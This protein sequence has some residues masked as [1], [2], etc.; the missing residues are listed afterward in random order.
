[1]KSK[2]ILIVVILV[3]ASINLAP[4]YAKDS[5]SNLDIVIQRTATAGQYGVVHL[6]DQF[7]LTNIGTSPVSTFDFGFDRFYGNN[8]YYV[9]ARDQQGT[10][11]ML[12]AD[13]NQTSPFLWIR[14]H[15][16]NALQPKVTYNFTVT[17]VLNGV[18]RPVSL[19]FEYNFTAAPILTQDAK[20]VNCTL[21]VPAGST[22]V[23]I[24][25]ST[26]VHSTVGGYPILT[27]QYKPWKAYSNTLFYGPFR[28]VNIYFIDLDWEQREISILS[29]GTLAIRE[30]FHF[31]NRAAVISNLAITLPSAATDVMAYDEV[32]PLWTSTQTP[33]SSGVVSVAPRSSQG[34]RGQEN[35]TVT[36]TYK[37]PQN[38]Y[39]KRLS[40]WGNYNLTFTLLDSRDDFLVQSATVKIITPNGLS[41]TGLQAPP[42]LSLLSPPIQ[43]SQDYRTI[44]LRGI[45]SLN[46]VTFSMA[47]SYS[48]FWSAFDFLP[49]IVGIEVVI[50][51]FALVFRRRRPEVEVPAPVEKLREFVGL[52][53]ERLALS[54]ELVVM[55]ED[56]ARGSLV[57]HEFRRRK[58]VMDARLDEVN[59]SLMQLKIDLRAV[60]PHYDELV[61]RI[62]RSEAEVEASRASLTQVRGQYR[63]GRTTREAYDHLVNDITKR[64]DRAQ[65]AIETALIT[66]REEAR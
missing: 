37:V 59:R 4:L 36:L 25:N 22:F 1:M 13:V 2:L 33:S 12:D 52:Y 43:V 35:F 34:L 61:R 40:G 44:T 46:N 42:L 21:I 39:V 65:E 23:T 7:S 14:A 41:I 8:I 28:S 32:G 6:T 15:F 45:T 17:S 24:P 50:V 3:L 49:W 31:R 30:K 18:L 20:L 47:F 10:S 26:Y 27:N 63:A 54:R 60:S 58:K 62:D 48:P 64:I 5:P 55:D 19:G 66:L 9:E 56:V 38:V 51:G 29:T 57:K 11:L 16:P 53:D